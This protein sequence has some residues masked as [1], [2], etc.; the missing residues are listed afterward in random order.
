MKDHV[1]TLLVEMYPLVSGLVSLIVAQ[2]LK[3]IYTYFRENRIDS[4]LL[5]SSG[6]MPSSHGAMVIGLT[7]AIGLQEGW[8]SALFCVS[9]VFSLIVLYDAAGI[10]RAAGL[11]AALLNQLAQDFF[12]KG[13]I[14]AEKLTELLGHTPFEVIIGSLLGVGVAFSLYY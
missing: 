13:E 2:V 5:F 1:V 14:K 8:T 10:R 7:T 11:Q 12:E 9:I 6:G 3:V 4:H